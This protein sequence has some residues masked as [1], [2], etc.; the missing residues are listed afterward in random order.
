ML[1]ICILFC[2]AQYFDNSKGSKKIVQ[3]DKKGSSEELNKSSM[4]ST[5]GDDKNQ[6]R[7]TESESLLNIECFSRD[8]SNTFLCRYIRQSSNCTSLTWTRT[9]ARTLSKRAHCISPRRPES[10][11]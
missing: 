2:C 1:N 5:G 8:A 10:K 9:C 3:I 11:Q 6:V 7:A 4:S